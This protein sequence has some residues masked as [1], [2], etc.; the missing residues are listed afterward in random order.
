[1]NVRLQ[2]IDTDTGE[3]LATKYANYAFNFAYKGDVGF[4][5]II[6]WAHSCVRGIRNTEHKNIELRVGFC[7]EKEE[8]FLPFGMTKEESIKNAAEYVY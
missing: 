2:M 3:I 5:T 8:L 4:T 1:M 6:N 7:E